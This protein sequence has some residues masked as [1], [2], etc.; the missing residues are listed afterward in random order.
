MPFLVQYPLVRLEGADTFTLEEDLHYQGR[1]QVF[2][3]PAGT[4]T[5]FAS[6]PR[7]LTWLVPNLGAY[8]KAAILHDWFCELLELRWYGLG[9]SPVNSTDADGMLRRIMREEGVSFPLR[10]LMWAGVRWGS[11]WQPHRRKG[12]L[13]DLPLVLLI[14][15]IALPVVLPA[16]VGILIGLLLYWLLSRVLPRR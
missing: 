12:V 7:V 2:V 11:V 4:T 6:V 10:W 15:L 13:K 5:D 1:D 8:N 14:S 9:E 3:V 16:A